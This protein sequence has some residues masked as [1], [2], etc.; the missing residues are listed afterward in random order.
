MFGELGRSFKTTNAVVAGHGPV[1][2]RTAI[3]TA[4]RVQGV[5]EVTPSASTHD[6]PEG[7][8]GGLMMPTASLNSQRTLVLTP[9]LE[10]M[11]V[12]L[13]NIRLA[14][15]RLGTIYPSPTSRKWAKRSLVLLGR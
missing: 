2:Y 12:A 5:A 8:D 3:A 13:L 7:G 6:S 1:G 10:G 4:Q 14:V 15:V 11:A 9:P